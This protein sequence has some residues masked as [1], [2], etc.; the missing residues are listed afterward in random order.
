MEPEGVKRIFEWSENDRSLQY[1]GYIG[2]GDSKSYS[3]ILKVDPYNGKSIKK[4]DCV[5]HL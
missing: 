2:D 5:G 4:Y 3:Y 1:T